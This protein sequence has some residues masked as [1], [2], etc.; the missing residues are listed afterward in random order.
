MQFII[1]KFKNDTIL[2][3]SGIFAFISCFFVHPDFQYIKYINYPV[4]AILFSLMLIVSA[5]MR[6][7]TFDFLTN[8]ILEKIH[9]ER[10]IA[11]LFVLLSF[12][13]SMFLTNDVTLVTL[14]PFAIMVLNKISDNHELMITLIIMT[15]ASNLGSMFTPIGNPQNLYLYSTYNMNMIDFLNLMLP[16]SIIS[17]VLSILFVF[18]ENKN[19]KTKDDIIK[20]DVLKPNIYKLSIYI[21]LF[22]L[23]IFTVSGQV[24]FLIMLFVVSFV[25]LCMDYK[26]FKNAD[27][28]LLLTFVFFFVLIGNIGRI[29]FI[30]SM[31]SELIQ[32]NVVLTAIFSSQIISNVPTAI[33]LSAFTENGKALIVGTNLGGLGTIIASMASLITYKFYIKLDEN[34]KK[35]ENYIL[36]FSIVNIIFLVVLYVVYMLIK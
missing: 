18:W 29:D 28:S 21:L 12:F 10:Y 7:G 26:A 9:S 1:K 36:S 16:Y 17:L 30:H 2:F 15:V 4:L 25:I 14:I 31:I 13:M 34:R 8:K 11:I 5:M 3:L 35:G 20:K 27:Y 32:K 6:I 33:L 19:K 23:C 22:I 24:N